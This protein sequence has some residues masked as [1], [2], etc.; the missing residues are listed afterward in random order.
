MVDPQQAAYELFGI[1]LELP[2]EQRSAYLDRV[3]HQAPELRRA[4]EELLRTD[5]RAPGSFPKV[6][7]DGLTANLSTPTEFKADV[8][9]MAVAS[10]RSRFQTSQ[11]IANR[12][13][14]V[15]FIA[16]GGMG[17][18][19]EVLD[20]LLQD[21]PVALKILRPSIAAD[22]GSAHRFEQEVL[23][24][25][26]VTHA[27]LCPI[28][29]IFHC[30]APAPP[31]Q[32]LTMKLL[33]GETLESRLGRAQR[34]TRQEML[35][36]SKQLF[37]GVAAMHDAGVIH[38]D[39]KPNNIMLEGSGEQLQ[40]FIMDFGLAR[41]HESESTL[42]GPGSVAG[43]PAYFAPELLGGHAPTQASDLFAMGVVLHRLLTGDFPTQARHGAP[44]TPKPSL[45]A[46]ETVPGIIKAVKGL[47]S[48][49]PDQR[50]RAFKDVRALDNANF[51]RA[52]PLPAAPSWTRRHFALVTT[53]S[54]CGLAGL[55]AWKRN[56]IYDRLHPLP[57][58][59]FVALLTW[60]PPYDSRVRPMLMGLIDAMAEEFARVEAFDRNFFVAAQ[61]TTTEM[62]TPD[63]LNEAREALGANLV[64]AISGVAA[65]QDVSV[66]L[67]VLAPA[68]PKALRSKQIRAPLDE[69]L[70][71][72]PLVI[73]AAAEML[74][75]ASYQPSERRK[76]VGT[77]KPEALAAFQA[78]ELYRKQENDTGLQPAVEKYKQALEIDPHYATAQARL[79]SAYLRSYAVNGDAAALILGKENCESAVLLNPDLVEAHL[80]LAWVL[81]T[82]GDRQAAYREMTK[83]LALDPS[84]PHT[85]SSQADLYADSGR[86]EEA[87]A[88][89]KRVLKLRPN[90]WLP[91]NAYGVL[92]DNQGRFA[93][94][95]IE[96][97]SASLAAPKNA[98]ALSNVG[99]V[100][101]QLGNLKRAIQNCKSSYDLEPNDTAALGLA[102]AFRIQKQYPEAIAYAQRATQLGP[103]SSVNWI[104]LGDSHA[105]AGDVTGAHAAFLRACAA[106][107]DEVRTEP[108]NG[109]GWT[110]LA[111][112]RA[113]IGPSSS[114]SSL[115]EKAETSH[116][117]DITSKLFKVRTLELLGRRDDAIA[118]IARCLLRGATAFQFQTM[119]DLQALRSDVRYQKLVDL[120][121]SPLNKAV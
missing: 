100:Y 62:M 2:R 18:V 70:S 8:G 115:L 58:K 59:R 7:L 38:R 103:A 51:T 109:A 27:N 107:E 76:E 10:D 16:R 3:C 82:T 72:P 67:H 65:D 118:E 28:Y 40:L 55:F 93:E 23:L 30:E 9:L 54:A 32:F 102:S 60:P 108:Q 48:E 13:T 50:C 117:D 112:C 81:E 80:G 44:S 104:E 86:Y 25:R 66:L 17:E 91:H 45:D 29:E 15:R 113:K 47:L 39:L 11:V 110:L 95:L 33:R 83:A 73:H 84:D 37:A 24:A 71:L 77:D 52:A 20:R 94:A 92:L 36:I 105:A 46:A 64:L 90:Y 98:L 35:L 4:V 75:I 89:F 111:L 101:L 116:A 121:A 99:S 85:L 74:D 26:K 97:R 88:T 68:S 1:V 120:S 14:V 119:P 57:Q 78:A 22:A 41:L 114:I 6:L 96:F 56:G 61:K 79:G 53:A 43:T 31:F 5:P 34:L 106:E 12:F 69:Q 63:Q 19:Y 42:F 49:Q 87:E 21:A